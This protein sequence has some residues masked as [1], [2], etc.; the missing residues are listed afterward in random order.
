MFALTEPVDIDPAL[1]EPPI[2]VMRV[3]LHPRGLG[4]L[5]VKIASYSVPEPEHD[6]IPDPA[7]RTTA[8]TLHERGRD[9]SPAG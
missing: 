3:G 1:P 2:N 7:D 5:L 9:R 6:A 4:P 8:E